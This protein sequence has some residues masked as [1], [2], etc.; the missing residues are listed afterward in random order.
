MLLTNGTENVCKP[1]VY[2]SSNRFNKN[3]KLIW[4]ENFD[5]W[6]LKKLSSSKQKVETLTCVGGQFSLKKKF[7]L[8]ETTT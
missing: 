6:L 5:F 2:V 1:I 4:N 8:P 3:A 7:K